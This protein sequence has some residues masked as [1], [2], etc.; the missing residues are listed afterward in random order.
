MQGAETF[1]G[2]HVHAKDFNDISLAKDKQVIILGAGKSALDCASEV[3]LSQ[4]A[5]S[6]TWLFRQVS[7]G[8]GSKTVPAGERWFQV[9]AQ[10][11]ANVHAI[12][13][14]IMG[15]SCGVEQEL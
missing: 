14:T 2:Q 9:H 8:L 7:C 1:Q 10:L 3:A 13:R 5:K 15:D 11:V 12:V 6:V 4:V